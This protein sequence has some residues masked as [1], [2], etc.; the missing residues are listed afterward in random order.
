MFFDS[1]KG[2]GEGRWGLYK[3][4]PEGQTL[5]WSTTRGYLKGVSNSFPLIDT[6]VMELLKPSATSGA[7]SEAISTKKIS[8]GGGV[9]SYSIL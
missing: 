7:I 6:P 2:L 5:L 9:P 4:P 3:A 1:I 8:S